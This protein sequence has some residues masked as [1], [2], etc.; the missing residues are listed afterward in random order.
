MS[1]T[2]IALIDTDETTRA[3]FSDPA[4][5]RGLLGF[6]KYWGKKPAEPLSYLIQKLCPPNGIVCDPFIGYGTTAVASLSAKRRVIGID[7][8]PVAIRIARL[9]TSPPNLI[10]VKQSLATIADLVC[11]SIAESYATN[12][13]KTGTHYVWRS[14]EMQKVWT[15][16]QGNRIE[17][18][19]TPS[20]IALAN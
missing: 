10:K 15:E 17:F 6:H 19:P 16:R 5:Y 8:N 3:A 14:N 1:T 20:D 13:E 12:Q 18:T 9:I 11:N 2:Q 4:P 7:L